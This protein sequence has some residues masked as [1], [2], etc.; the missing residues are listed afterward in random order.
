MES[1]PIL[2]DLLVLVGVAL[3][4]A[5][6]AHRI[7]IP[8]L[9]GFLATGVLIGPHALRFVADARSVNQLAEVGVVLLLFAVGLELSLARILRTG[10]YVIRGGTVQLLGTMAVV[11]GCATLLG[12][13]PNE[14]A[15]WGALVALSSTAIVLKVYADLGELDSSHG[16][17]VVAILLFQDLCVVPLMLLLPFLAGTAH[18]PGAAL[19][20][21]LLT[22]LVTGGLV[23]GG[24]A[25]VPGVLRRVTELRNQEIFTLS[26]LAIGLGAA[27]LT[28][29]FGL[30]LALGAFLAGLLVS[31]SEYGLQALSDVLPFRDTF[32][33]IF[34]TSIG[35]LLDLRFVG[36]HLLLV[37]GVAVGIV[38]LKATIAF[39]AV[40]LVRRSARVAV[41]AGLGLAQVG[42]FSFVLAGLAGTTGLMSGEDFQVFLAAAV[43]T[44]LAA[45]FVV[46]AAPTVAE[47][48]L[49]YRRHTTMEFATREA[50]AARMLEGHV[51]IVGYG[52][53]GR[54]LARAL[55]SAGIPYVILESNGHVV[56]QA[57]LE[58]EPIYFGDGTRA[59]VLER[60]GIARA[61]VVVFAIA[62]HNDEVRGIAVAR[63]LNPGIH[64]V[65]RTRY[66]A[67]MD[68]LYSAG[69]DEV[70][71]EEFETSLEI[72][73]R[74]LRRY[75][76]PEH[77][78]RAQAEEARRDHYELL[79]QRGRAMQRVDSLLARPP[80]LEVRSLAGTE[81]GID[82]PVPLEELAKRFAST[83]AARIV[84]VE[85]QGR[86][87]LDLHDRV[88]HPSDRVFLVG[89]PQALEKILDRAKSGLPTGDAERARTEQ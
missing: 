9:V 47:R 49:A 60:V 57:R 63:H 25:V 2:R 62:S 30:S 46:S 85:S 76:V 29:R 32:S 12:K 18:G 27:F 70:V 75:R 45:P 26:V 8:T 36:Q 58:R 44:M 33:G 73:A 79:R 10:R 23:L 89:T 65:A 34:F 4:V 88:V 80:D 11:A 41:L 42:E 71:P 74:V 39:L 69:A 48:L 87:E 15:L 52:L 50:R 68:E 67:D 28:S 81:L 53:N 59:D 14:A 54:N 64:I 1:A 38:L 20:A 61:R 72:F 56:R 82:A 22:V 3:P 43:V 35:M 51:V 16:R 77:A 78:I 5:I 21:A 37:V 7:R 17:I 31:E 40:R 66:V 19:R 55:R 86:I 6:L 84:A 24:R 13:P 83:H